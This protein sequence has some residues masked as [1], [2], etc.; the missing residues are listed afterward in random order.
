VVAAAD[1]WDRAAR[2]LD[3]YASDWLRMYGD[4]CAATHLR[5]EQ[6]AMAM[7]NRRLDVV[8]ARMI[9]GV[10]SIMAKKA[11]EEKEP[12]QKGEQRAANA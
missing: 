2:V 3:R 6:S 11:V 8:R 4:T 1:T 5:G 12:K 9:V 7:L 10:L